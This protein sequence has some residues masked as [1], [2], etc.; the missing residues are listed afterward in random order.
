M[1]ATTHATQDHSQAAF[2]GRKAAQRCE[3]PVMSFMVFSSSLVIFTRYYVWL[4]FV[5]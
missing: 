5:T 4:R 1:V 3:K 2:D